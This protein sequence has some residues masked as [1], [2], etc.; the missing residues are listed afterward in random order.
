LR[1]LRFGFGQARK[2]GQAGNKSNQLY[3]RLYCYNEAICPEDRRRSW[4]PLVPG[5]GVEDDDGHAAVVAPGGL[6]LV[7]ALHG[8]VVIEGARRQPHQS[9]CR[10]NPSQRWSAT[11]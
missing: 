3:T 4:F 9:A 7:V 2:Q 1:I 11:S 5:E 8:D 6:G 10:I